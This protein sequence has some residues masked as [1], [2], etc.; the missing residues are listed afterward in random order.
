MNNTLITYKDLFSWG[1]NELQAEKNTSEYESKYLI[2]LLFD[3]P[4]KKFDSILNTKAKNQKL[5]EKFIS[6]IKKRKK[7]TPLAYLLNTWFFKEKKYYVDKGVFIPRPET[8]RVVNATKNLISEMNYE[9]TDITILEIGFGTGVISIE[10]A[11]LYY[12]L[13]ILSWDINTQALINAKKNTTLYKTKNTTFI[14]KDFFEDQKTWGPIIHAEK[15]VIIVGNPPYI[16][17]NHIKNLY[18]IVW[19]NEPIDALA[20]GTKGLDFY[21]KLFEIASQ[22]KNNSLVLEFGLNQ[23][24]LLKKIINSYKN[25][26]IHIISAKKSIPKVLVVKN[27]YY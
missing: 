19:Q 14:N 8:E 6:T 20:G 5:I 27:I 9:L 18:P 3:I 24:T 15:P 13:K 10:L 22:G 26:K 11:Q 23:E 12:D 21:I 1:T 25:K 4:L 7:G 2:C 17:N 16:P